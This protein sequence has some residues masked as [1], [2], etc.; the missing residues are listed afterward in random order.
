MADLVNANKKFY[1]GN[2]H[3]RIDGQYVLEDN[4]RKK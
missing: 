4:L 2:K 1:L 3:I